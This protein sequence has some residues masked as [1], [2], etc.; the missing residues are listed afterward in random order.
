MTLA[1]FV[2]RHQIV[3]RSVVEVDR[4]ALPDEERMDVLMGVPDERCWEVTLQASAPDGD[5]RCTTRRWWSVEPPTVEQRV[6]SALRH[7]RLADPSRSLRRSWYDAHGAGTVRFTVRG[8]EQL[9]DLWLEAS[10]WLQDLI[11]WRAYEEGIKCVV[12]PDRSQTPGTF[13][14]GA[15]TG[16]IRQATRRSY[17][18]GYPVSI[19]VTPSTLKAWR[20]IEEEEFAFGGRPSDHVYLLLQRRATKMHIEDPEEAM[21]LY[22]SAI[23]AGAAEGC[24]PWTANALVAYAH[25]IA[26]QCE[27]D[28]E[29]LAGSSTSEAHA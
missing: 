25:R 12:L 3:A 6:G 8:A 17:L 9:R 26:E 29:I 24:H 2:Q 16:R 10:R 4:A 20:E 21:K 23:H 19:T 11:G 15:A 5:A 18:P 14:S 7:A 27:W 1:D 28:T 13:G 22:W